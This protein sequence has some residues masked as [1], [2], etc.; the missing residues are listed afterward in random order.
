MK[1]SLRW[2]TLV[3]IGLAALLLVPAIS[4]GEG[5]P[6]SSYPM[7]AAPRAQALEFVVPVGLTNAGETVALSTRTIAGTSDPLIAESLM[8]REIRAG[9]ASQLCD[10][11]AERIDDGPIVDIEVR[12]E[13]HQVT[14]RALGRPSLITSE[15]VATCP[16][17]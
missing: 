12:R 10:S 6:L 15:V 3:T 14:E 13:A 1:V 8:W 9:R 4:G 5:V 7:Y 16:T 17:R 2:R 11:I